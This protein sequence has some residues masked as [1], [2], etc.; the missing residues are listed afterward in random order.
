MA[1]KSYSDVLQQI[2]RLQAEQ[3]ALQAQA[4][5]LK[6]EEVQGVISRIREA[7]ESYELTPEDLFGKRRGRGIAKSKRSGGGRPAKSGSQGP[8]YS[9][10][11]GNTWGGRGP[12]PQWLRDALAA[13][14]ELESFLIG[15]RRKVPSTDAT[16]A[17]PSPKGRVASKRAATKHASS[18]KAAPAKRGRAKFRSKEAAPAPSPAPDASQE[19]TAA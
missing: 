12:R 17:K 8:K 9:D 11:Q 14:A 19:A 10:G 15:A 6:R 2:Q 3:Q 7:I 18:K 5:A 1:K 13:G 16:D 4:E